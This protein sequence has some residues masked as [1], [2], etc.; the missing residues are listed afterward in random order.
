MYKHLIAS[1]I[2]LGTATGLAKAQAE[3]PTA[4]ITIHPDQCDASYRQR[5]EVIY[6]KR[7][8]A[9]EQA[10]RKQF[11][12]PMLAAGEESKHQSDAST[13]ISEAQ[14]ERANCVAAARAATAQEQ[15]TPLL[16]RGPTVTTQAQTAT[17]TRPKLLYQAE[18]PPAAAHGDAQRVMIYISAYWDAKC[19]PS[20]YVQTNTPGWKFYG[21][22]LEQ[23]NYRDYMEARPLAGEAREHIAR[24]GCAAV[25]EMMRREWPALTFAGYEKKEE[26]VPTAALDKARPYWRAFQF[27][28]YARFCELRS[29]GYY[30]VFQRARFDASL[31]I[32][33]ARL[34]PILYNEVARLEDKR[35]LQNDI[36]LLQ[37]RNRGHLDMFNRSNPTVRTM[38]RALI[39][40]PDILPQL[41]DMYL[42]IT[43]PARRWD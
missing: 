2:A 31:P 1:L 42:Y 4:P 11:A 17:P 34:D 33:L 21:G 16:E 7:D 19:A 22:A 25:A 28:E 38:C 20:L 18:S 43:D 27:A 29:I 12:T 8:K 40:D 32:G 35:T 39:D 10:R 14:Q 26:P 36:L 30:N 37:W 23:L 3:Q 9:I 6:E 13:K 24:E 5:I 41:D 15:T